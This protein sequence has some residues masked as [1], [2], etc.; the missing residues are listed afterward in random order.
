MP[1]HA[2]KK[3]IKRAIGRSIRLWPLPHLV[4]WK[5]HLYTTP[6]APLPSSSAKVISAKGMGLKLEAFLGA[7][8]V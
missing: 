3:A 1:M 2:I 5:V 4:A 8:S 6:K 7:S